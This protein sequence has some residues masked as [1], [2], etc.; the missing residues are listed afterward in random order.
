MTI[1]PLSLRRLSVRIAIAV[2][3]LCASASACATVLR[4]DDG[5]IRGAEDAAG[6][7]WRSDGTTVADGQVNGPD[8]VTTDDGPVTTDDGGQAPDGTGP[9]DAGPRTLPDGGPI[10]SKLLRPASAVPNAGV[11]VNGTTGSDSLCGP[12]ASHVL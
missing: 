5:G 4:I 3:P 10:P 12:F 7:E 11:F 6:P 9:Q 2:V 1:A 8:A